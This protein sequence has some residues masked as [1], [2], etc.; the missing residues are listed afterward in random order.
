VKKIILAFLVCAVSAPARAADAPALGWWLQPTICRPSNQSCYAGVGA[1][2]PG[3]RD[4]W[5]DGAACR[6]KKVICENALSPKSALSG[7]ESFSKAE[8]AVSQKSV[9][10]GDPMTINTADFDISTLDTRAH[11]DE[12]FGVRRTRNNGTRASV[13]GDWTDVY[14]PGAVDGLDYEEIATGHVV[15]SGPKP[16]CDTL[17]A[18]GY[19][20]ILNGKCYGKGGFTADK[21]YL[22]QCGGALLPDLIVIPNGATVN[23]TS[24]SH[25]KT[26]ADANAKFNEMI[27]RAAANQKNIVVE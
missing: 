1:N 21:N 4:E 22:V 23:G 12:C 20:K 6:G 26:E 3:F 16:T 2:E 10:G 9:D 7:N 24:G 27:G 13:G 19:I 18:N 25:P 17:K 8:I 5:D 11:N 15:V 14:C